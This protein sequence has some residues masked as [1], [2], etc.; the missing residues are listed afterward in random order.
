MKN[1][2]ARSFMNKAKALNQAHLES[3]SSSH[4]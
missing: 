1:V 3:K 2:H 4:E